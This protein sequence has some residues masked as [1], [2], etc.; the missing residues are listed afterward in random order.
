MQTTRRMNRD[1]REMAGTLKK[2]LLRYLQELRSIAVDEL[3][4]QRYQKFRRMGRLMEGQ[5]ANLEPSAI[6]A[7]QPNA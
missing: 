2:Y 5:P 6:C 3:L 1:H 7:A 4:D